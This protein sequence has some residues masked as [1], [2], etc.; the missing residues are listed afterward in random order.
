MNILLGILLG[1]G[2]GVLSGLFGI[3]GGL[4]IVPVLV[5]VG[6]SQHEAS[7]TSLAALLA[8]V[9]LFGVLQY[10]HRGQIN[11]TIGITIAIGMILG[12]YFGARYAG[13]ISNYTLQ[14]SFGAFMVVAG[15]RFLLFAKR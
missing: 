8:P 13:R 1:I 2:A 14:R 12:T 6:M 7:G 5:L 4:V 15:L 11:W 10:A 9:A 3:G